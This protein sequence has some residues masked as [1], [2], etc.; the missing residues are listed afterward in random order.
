MVSRQHGEFYLAEAGDLCFRDHSANG[1]FV[2]ERLTRNH[3]ACITGDAEIKLSDSI[4]L[5]V[6]PNA[7]LF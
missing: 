1:T 5:K 6:T 3:S 2:N 4:T 7:K